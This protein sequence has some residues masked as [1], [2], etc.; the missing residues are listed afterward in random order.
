MERDIRVFIKACDIC[1]RCKYHND[2]YPGLLQPL[3]VPTVIWSEI[4]MDFIGLPKSARKEVIMVVVDM[5]SKY[6]HFI[7]FHHPFSAATVAEV[8]LNN[9]FKLHGMPLTI[10][11]DRDSIFLCTFW[12]QFFRL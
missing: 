10:V 5:L 9:I 4:S 8:F 1:Q 6:A 2:A 3:L 11:S 7:G 12:Q